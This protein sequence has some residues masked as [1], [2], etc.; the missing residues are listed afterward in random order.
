VSL[1]RAW[2]RRKVKATLT[3]SEPIFEDA[4]LISGDG[5][6]SSEAE[7]EAGATHMGDDSRCTQRLPSI[8]VGPLALNSS[9][10][11]V[12][13]LEQL[14]EIRACS[15]NPPPTPVDAQSSSSGGLHKD[16]PARDAGRGIPSYQTYVM[17]YQSVALE[18]PPLLH[19]LKHKEATE[20]AR[21]KTG[22]PQPVEPPLSGWQPLL[23]YR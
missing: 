22:L 18:L 10:Q 12:Q 1:I 7:Y 13:Q 14:S 6:A 9:Q 15:S 5:T 17:Q 21:Q 19:D 16:D 11:S 2:R 20:L 8:S 4:A 23:G 3:V